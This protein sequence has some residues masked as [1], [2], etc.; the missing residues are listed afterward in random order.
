MFRGGGG[1]AEGERQHLNICLGENGWEKEALEERWVQRSAHHH[2]CNTP[3]LSTPADLA[4][5]YLRAWV[6]PPGQRRRGTPRCR[7][8]VA[9]VH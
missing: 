9:A 4:V 6:N 2:G 1:R 7:C 8:R 5:N 3:L